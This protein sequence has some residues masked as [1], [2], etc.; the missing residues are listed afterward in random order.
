MR[1]KS[2]ICGL[3]ALEVARICVLGADQKKS[4]LWRRDWD[5]SVTVVLT[6]MHRS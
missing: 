4:E 5:G 2:V 6:I 1:Q 3:P